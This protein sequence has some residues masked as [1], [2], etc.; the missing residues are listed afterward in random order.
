MCN[1]VRPERQLQPHVIRTLSYTHLH[2]AL[3][4]SRRGAAA[5]RGF[6]K[7]NLHLSDRRDSTIACDE[8]RAKVYG[9]ARSQKTLSTVRGLSTEN[10][11]NSSQNQIQFCVGYLSNSVDES[12]FVYGDDLGDICDRISRKAR[13]ASG[14]EYIARSVCPGQVTGERNADHGVDTASIE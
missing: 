1:Q 13:H 10:G 5:R 9:K 8:V 6:F 3:K 14:E 12:R 4:Q 7:T 11:V 2:V